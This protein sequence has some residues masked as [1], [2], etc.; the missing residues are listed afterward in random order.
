MTV[1]LV[2]SFY[3]P[4]V[5]QQSRLKLEVSSAMNTS[6]LSNWPFLDNNDGS[7]TGYYTAN[8]IGTYKVF[9]LFD[10]KH[11]SPPSFE[12]NVYAGK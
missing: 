4:I 3:N 6:V 1:Q 11:L 8:D 2:D 5:S 12:V 10:D 9:P 7:Y